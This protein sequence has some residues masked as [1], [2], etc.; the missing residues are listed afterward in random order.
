MSLS[1]VYMI[2]AQESLANEWLYHLHD[3]S[4][5][6]FLPMFFLSTPH[7]PPYSLNPQILNLNYPMVSKRND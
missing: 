4:D 2:A 3:L 5:F 1:V 6:V 7:L